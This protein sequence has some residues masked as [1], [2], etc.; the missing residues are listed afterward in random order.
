MASSQ[1]NE[2]FD[3]YKAE[4]FFPRGQPNHMLS[5]NCLLEGWMIVTIESGKANVELFRGLMGHHFLSLSYDLYK[6][7]KLFI[8]EFV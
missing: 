6:D 4:K 5:L 3:N 7:G 8:N 1:V 2:L